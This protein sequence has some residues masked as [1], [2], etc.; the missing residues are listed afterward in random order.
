MLFSLII[1]KK[2]DPIIGIDFGISNSRV[3]VYINGKVQ[4]IPNDEG[5]FN[6]QSI[7]SFNKNGILVGD[8]AKK[9]NVK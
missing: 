9:W 4:F 7:V 1:D 2:I 5:S 3:A 8:K 6:T